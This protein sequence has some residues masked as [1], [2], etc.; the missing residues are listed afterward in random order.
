[1]TQLDVAY[2]FLRA[3]LKLHTGFGLGS[4]EDTSHEVQGIL[5]CQTACNRADN[6]PT[7]QLMM[8]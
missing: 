8:L 4:E 5:N 7:Q 3:V 6:F 1:M 2:T